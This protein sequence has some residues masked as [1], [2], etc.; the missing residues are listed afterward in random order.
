MK[1]AR[2]NCAQGPGSE[3]LHFCI[4]LGLKKKPEWA[5]S[6]EIKMEETLDFF[7]Y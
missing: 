1:I 2:I 6:T 5:T 3:D 7:K 4:I